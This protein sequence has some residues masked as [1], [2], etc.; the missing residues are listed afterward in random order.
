MLL[1]HIKWFAVSDVTQITKQ[2]TLNCCKFTNTYS[3]AY[4]GRMG[5]DSSK[6]KSEAKY[7]VRWRYAACINHVKEIVTKLC[8]SIVNAW[9]IFCPFFSLPIACPACYNLVQDRVDE[10]RDR[11]KDLSDLINNIGNN[12]DLVNDEDFERRL[13][14]LDGELNRTI[15][16]AEDAAG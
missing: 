13:R 8:I 6:N 16:E 15:A 10:H 4:T 2:K 5:Q 1:N 12:P 11:L 3:V 7:S 9:L 14:Q